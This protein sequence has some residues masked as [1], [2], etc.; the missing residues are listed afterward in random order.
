MSQKEPFSMVKEAFSKSADLSFGK[1]LL[2]LA[3]GVTI[4]PIIDLGEGLNKIGIKTG[5]SET[6]NDPHY[7]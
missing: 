7:D 2:Y 5:E 1:R 4:E 3:L 6:E